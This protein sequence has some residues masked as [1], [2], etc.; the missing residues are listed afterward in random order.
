MEQ[1]GNRQ[2]PLV[3]ATIARLTTLSVPGVKQCRGIPGRHGSPVPR[4][5]G[6]WRP[7]GPRR[8]RSTGHRGGDVNVLEPAR[9]SRAWPRHH[10]DGGMPVLAIN[11]RV[12]DVERKVPEELTSSGD[13]R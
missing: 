7:G 4:Q 1:V 10:R 3:L 6:R 12:E 8:R 9:S 13:S 2:Y 5:V 11:V